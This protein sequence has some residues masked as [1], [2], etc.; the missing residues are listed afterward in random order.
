MFTQFLSKLYPLPMLSLLVMYIATP[1]RYIKDPQTLVAICLLDSKV[2]S[3]PLLSQTLY[4]TVFTIGYS[5]R[6]CRT[7]KAQNSSICHT[8]CRAKQ[9]TLLLCILQTSPSLPPFGAG[10]LWA[11][12]F[13]I[14]WGHSLLVKSA[15]RL[16]PSSISYL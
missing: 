2:Q 14:N 12:A 5:T 11:F 7:I 6:H 16:P 13:E 1:V 3:Q 10:C 15:Q 9:C 4:R 8:F